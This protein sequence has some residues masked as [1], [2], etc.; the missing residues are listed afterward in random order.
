LEAASERYGEELKEDSYEAYFQEENNWDYKLPSCHPIVMRFLSGLCKIESKKRRSEAI[1][2]ERSGWV[3]EI[4]IDVDPKLVIKFGEKSRDLEK[5]PTPRVAIF[6]VVKGGGASEMGKAIRF[7]AWV[8]EIHDSGVMTGSGSGL[9]Q[10]KIVEG[11][12]AVFGISYEEAIS[13]KSQSSMP[14]ALY[15]G[16]SL[17]PEMAVSES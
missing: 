11:L 9:W 15:V 5:L 4:E 16:D 2:D 6:K 7:D 3:F 10:G 13:Q 17:I 8:R 1:L 14:F 12:V